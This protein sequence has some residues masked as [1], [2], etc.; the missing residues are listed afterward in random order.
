MRA[1]LSDEE[2]VCCGFIYIF[3]ADD[4]GMVEFFQDL[5]LIVKHFKARG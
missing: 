1:V 4:I 5:Y 3:E 2:T